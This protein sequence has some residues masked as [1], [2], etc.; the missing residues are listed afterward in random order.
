VI[1]WRVLP[2]DPSAR[3]DQPGG[4]VWFPRELQGAG[5]HDDPDAYGCL[6]VAEVAASAV[7]EALAPFRGAG[8]LHASMLERSGRRLSLVALE[9]DHT[10]ALVD[11]DDP[12]VLDAEELR[13]S[14]VATRRR[15]ITRAQ[16]RRLFDAHPGAP[17]LRWWS[18]LEASWIN[19][20]LFDRA[21]AA[22][23]VVQTAE[24][25]VEHPAARSAAEQLGLN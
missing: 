10:Q 3:A 8:R 9:L 21:A 5:R 19:A 18:P 17:G 25:T 14:L 6:Y 23:A 15:D 11:L 13:P 1:L 16:A 7:A 20:T 4:G 12:L 22:L 2:L 24:L